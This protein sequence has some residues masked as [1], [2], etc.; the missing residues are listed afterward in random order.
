MWQ[1]KIRIVR[2]VNIF[3]I[4]YGAYAKCSLTS[5][6]ATDKTSTWCGLLLL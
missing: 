3:P 4:F 6:F 1:L 2:A 5:L